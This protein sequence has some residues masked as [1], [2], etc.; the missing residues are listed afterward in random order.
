M[1]MNNV[2]VEQQLILLFI[3]END[4]NYRKMKDEVYYLTIS[5]YTISYM[6]QGTN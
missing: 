6:V 3:N 2:A 1:H 5:A 4:K